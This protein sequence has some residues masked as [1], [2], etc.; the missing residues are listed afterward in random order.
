[1]IL[2]AEPPSISMR[3]R[4]CSRID[5]TTNKG[6]LCSL[7]PNNKSSSVKAIVAQHGATF[8][9]VWCS[10]VIVG[11]CSHLLPFVSS[12][13]EITCVAPIWL[14]QKNFSGKNSSNVM[15]LRTFCDEEPLIFWLV[16]GLTLFDGCSWFTWLFVALV[17]GSRILGT[18][19][20]LHFLWV[21]KVQPSA[22][23]SF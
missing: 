22:S 12:V 13:L 23:F 20:C 1:M 10:C 11:L 21:T 14:P 7:D 16:Q 2:T 17:L 19:W 5:P 8:S 15:G 3:L 4:C 18:T 6:L 9:S